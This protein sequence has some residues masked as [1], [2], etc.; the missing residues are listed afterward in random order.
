MALLKIS[1]LTAEKLAKSMAQVSGDAEISGY[2]VG[3]IQDTKKCV[4]DNLRNRP[5]NDCDDLRLINGILDYLEKAKGDL[6]CILTTDIRKWTD[7]NN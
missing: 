5:N 2:L 6:S 3:L 1:A 7:N 4:E